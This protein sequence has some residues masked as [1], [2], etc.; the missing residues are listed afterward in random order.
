MIKRDLRKRT[1]TGIELR[2][3]KLSKT[4]Y[5]IN[6]RQQV[7]CPG[8]YASRPGKYMNIV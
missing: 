2:N 1:G 6:Y 7:A 4:K 8:H 5:R 3:K